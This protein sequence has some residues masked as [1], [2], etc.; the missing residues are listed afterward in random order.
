LIHN[1]NYFYEFTNTMRVYSIPGYKPSARDQED[2]DVVICG[3]NFVIIC[4]GHGPNPGGRYIAEVV[5]ALCAALIPPNVAICPESCSQLR[6][7][8]IEHVCAN[9]ENWRKISPD[10]GTTVLIVVFSPDGQTYLVVKLGDSYVLEIPEGFS[11]D[12]RPLA[13]D[14]VILDKKDSSDETK[15]G[16][17]KCPWQIYMKHRIE[18]GRGIRGAKAFLRNYGAEIIMGGNSFNRDNFK[19]QTM[20]IESTLVKPSEDIR[21]I[22]ESFTVCGIFQRKVGHRLVIASD[23]LPIH[24]PEIWAMLASEEALRAYFAERS[25]HDD[26]TVVVM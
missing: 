9:F 26:V 22:L 14:S 17:S 11:G 2:Q 1:F 15:W 24:K 16:T 12:G 21:Q 19:L 6:A 25:E 5:A 8:F 23:G 4:D 18:P 7:I 20:G 13:F 10:S 3:R